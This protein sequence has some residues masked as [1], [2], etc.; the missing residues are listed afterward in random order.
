[1][2]HLFTKKSDYFSGTNGLRTMAVCRTCWAFGDSPA[3][4]TSPSI[5]RESSSSPLT[6]LPWSDHHHHHPTVS[7]AE[8]SVNKS[9][10]GLGEPCGAPPGA[11]STNGFSMFNEGEGGGWR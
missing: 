10:A 1:M 6:F 3:S 7:E 5:Y 8:I 9:I 2:K 4:S 11:R